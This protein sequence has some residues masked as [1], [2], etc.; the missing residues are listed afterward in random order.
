MTVRQSCMLRVL[1]WCASRN[2]IFCRNPESVASIQRKVHSLLAG[3]DPCQ[4]SKLFSL[5]L[6]GSCPRVG[7]ELHVDSQIATMTLNHSKVMLKLD[8]WL[9]TAPNQLTNNCTATISI[10]RLKV[11]SPVPPKHQGNSITYPCEWSGSEHVFGADA[12]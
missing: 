1:A 4:T 8:Q 12:I 10:G 9:Q 5:Q 7:L 3:T 6:N 2:H 11:R